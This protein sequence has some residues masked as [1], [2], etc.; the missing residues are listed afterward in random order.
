MYNLSARGQP[1]AG[2]AP[3]KYACRSHFLLLRVINSLIRHEAMMVEFDIL[4]YII[5]LQK[6]FFCITTIDEGYATM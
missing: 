5:K 2:V 6:S 3:I 1:E 4:F